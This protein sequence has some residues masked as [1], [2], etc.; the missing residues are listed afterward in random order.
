MDSPLGWRTERCYLWRVEALREKPTTEEPQEAWAQGTG[1]AG[2]TERLV[3]TPL[4]WGKVMLKGLQEL[5]QQSLGAGDLE[6]E[7]GSSTHPESTSDETTQV[8]SSILIAK[9]KMSHPLS[10]VK[11][12]KK[13][14]LML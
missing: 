6:P 1:C 12:K 3:R 7:A 11:K 5:R 9:A 10:G 14:S 8:S 13:K 4:F 2:G